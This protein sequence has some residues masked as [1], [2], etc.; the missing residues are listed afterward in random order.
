MTLGSI[1]F[2]ARTLLRGTGRDR[3]STQSHF[4]IALGVACVLLGGCATG[5]RVQ[6]QSSRFRAAD[7]LV[8][9]DEI[10]DSLAASSLLAGRSATTQ[11]PMRLYVLPAENLSSERLSRVDGSVMMSMVALDPR[12]MDLLQSKNV[13]IYYPDDTEKL[14]KRFYVD[15]PGGPAS[16][17]ARPGPTHF[18]TGEVRSITRQAGQQAQAASDARSDL[19]SVTFRLTDA[20]SN[21]ALWAHDVRVRR[22]AHGVVAD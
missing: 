13:E 17:D 19:F 7:M 6:G 5:G 2:D 3:R 11:P 14:L 8:S 22:V 9:T 4:A 21:V 1:H 12:M 16:M 18:L 20:E 10:T 15:V